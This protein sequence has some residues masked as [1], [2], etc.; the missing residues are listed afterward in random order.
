MKEIDD[1]MTP[2]ELSREL[3][4]TLPKHKYEANAAW[5]KAVFTGL[6][7]GGI[8]GWMEANRVFKKVSDTHFVEL[9]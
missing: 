9:E 7:L 6:K 8:W 4:E 3:W 1:W 2:D 5:L